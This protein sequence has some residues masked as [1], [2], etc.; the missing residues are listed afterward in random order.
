MEL[1]CSGS[2]YFNANTTANLRKSSK[3]TCLE[4]IIIPYQLAIAVKYMHLKNFLHNDIKAN[5]VLLK[6]KEGNWIPKLTNM[7][8]A[9]LKSEPEVYRSSATQ[10]EKYNKKYPHLAYELLNVFGAKASFAS[11]VYSLGYIFNYLP[12]KIFYQILIW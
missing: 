6:L 4:W 11:D 7:D 2:D 8:S 9:T 3:I 10:T 5:S 12:I 1:I